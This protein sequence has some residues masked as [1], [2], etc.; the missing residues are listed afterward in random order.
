MILYV[1]GDSHAA[2]AQAVNR[3]SFANDD[4]NHIALGRKPHPDN[5]RMSWG[6][7]L[8]KLLGLGLK[9]DAESGSSNARILRTTRDFVNDLPSLGNPYT[10]IVI[11]WSTWE[12]KEFWHADSREWLQFAAGGMFKGIHED[13]YKKYILDLDYDKDEAQCHSDIYDLHIEL[14][15]K[16]IP[17]LFFNAMWHFRSNLDLDWHGNY[18]EPYDPDWSYME[19]AFQNKFGERN[20]HYGPD[21]HRLWAD[22][23]FSRLTDML[24]SV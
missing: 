13:L 3:F 12:R 9:C 10:V 8:S 21:A 23:L 14:K 20:Q 16:N 5:L 7:R 4:I 1:N 24:E 22:V 19:W 17:H 6:M 15:Q 11:G 18:L 2:A